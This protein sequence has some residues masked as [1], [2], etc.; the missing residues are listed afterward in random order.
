MSSTFDSLNELLRLAKYTTPEIRLPIKE[1]DCPA[2]PVCES[3]GNLRQA[4]CAG[5]SLLTNPDANVC[6]ASLIF[7]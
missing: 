7:D 2:A 1:N 4:C 5:S 6:I 3:V